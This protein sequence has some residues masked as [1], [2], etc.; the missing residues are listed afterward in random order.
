MIRPH[1]FGFNQ[2]TAG[3]NSF[4]NNTGSKD[5]QRLALLESERLMQALSDAGVVLH[6][7]DNPLVS[8]P[9]AV[10]PNNWF[11]THPD[12]TWIKYPMAA[13]NRRPERREEICAWLSKRYAKHIDYS[14]SEHEGVFLEGTGSLV[15]DHTTRRVYASLSGR[16]DK[17]L[18]MRWA[19]AMNMQAFAFNTC[20]NGLPVYHTNVVMAILA[21]GISI[22]CTKVIVDDSPAKLLV[23]RGPLIEV[24]VEAML[25]LAANCI[26]LSSAAGDPVLLIGSGAWQALSARDRRLL[27]SAHLVIL[28]AIPTIEQIG[29]GG[30]R[31]MVAELF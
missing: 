5:I 21:G 29:G 18:L 10:F 12:G 19:D 13:A 25:K 30:V 23:E 14:E 20:Y 27:E 2:E 24:G 4:Q 26:A 7:F 8:C 31:C 11:S 3:S 9:D 22:L 15:I 28:A 16:T 17:A 6:A 1:F